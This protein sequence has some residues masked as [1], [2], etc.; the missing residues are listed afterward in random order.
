MNPQIMTF[1]K[2]T[3]IFLAILVIVIA[4][5]NIAYIRFIQ[6][7]KIVERRLAS[8]ENLVDSLENPVIDYMFFGDSHIEG[9]INP[10]YIDGVSFNFSIGGQSYTETYYIL[11]K[12]IEDGDVKFNNIVLQLDPHTFSESVRGGKFLFD[13]I[14]FYSKFVD[15][16]KMAELKGESFASVFLR[17]KFPFL[18]NGKYFIDSI[19]KL[20]DLTSM[21]LGWQN[22]HKTTYYTDNKEEIAKESFQ[23]YFSEGSA[24]I[25]K[26]T[27]DYFL[28]TLRLAK[29]NNINVVFLRYPISEE[30]YSEIDKN[31]DLD[32][33]YGRIFAEAD[34]ILDDYAVIDL[35][36]YFFG[37]GEYYWDPEHLT[38]PGAEVFSKKMNEELKLKEI[39]GVI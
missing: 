37:M 32:D 34:K 25:D 6:P 24:I 14:Y 2:K 33:Y 39:Y 20:D 35:H 26:V 5:V 31:V 23:H 12:L 3:A 18:G 27:F 7:Q 30:Y 16:R 22:T 28:E 36:D 15:A 21:Y 13:Q 17:T 29:E 10:L 4:L 8:Y 19:L 38:S 11:K 1:I 9:A